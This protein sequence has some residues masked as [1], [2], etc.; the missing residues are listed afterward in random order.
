MANL[1]IVESPSKAAAIKKYLGSNYKVI[2]SKG[3]VR[4]LPKS[5]LSVDIEN[6]FEA[7]YINIRGKGDLIREIRKEA[8]AAKKIFLAPDPD[9]EGEAIAWHLAGALN[10][11]PAKMLRVSFNEITPDVVRAA[12]KEPRAIDMNL[13]NA[14]QTRR[15]WDRVVGYKLS[16]YLWKSVKNGLSAGRVQSV[17][18]RIIVDREE[19]IRAFRPEEYWTIDAHLGNGEGKEFAVR[20]Y[21][22]AEGKIKLSCEQE[23]TDV[24]N[25]VKNAPFLVTSVKRATRQKLPAPPFTTSTMQQEASRKLGFQSQRIMRVAQELYEGINVGPE[26]GGVLGL[27]T[28]MRTDSLRVSAE[29]QNAARE[30]ISEKYGAEYCPAKPRV[31]KTRANAQD[32]HEAIRPSHIDLEPAK[33]HKYLTVDQYRLYKLIWERFVASQ[34]QS[35]S[36]NTLN[37]ELESAGYLFRAG[38]YSVAFPGYM[39]VY[40]ES[41]DEETRADAISEQKDVRIPDLNEGEHVEMR[42]VEPNRHFTE[43]PARY[44]E[45]SLI[46]FLDEKGIGRPSTY[47]TIITTIVTRNYVVRDGKSLVPTPLGEVTTKLMKENFS[48][49]V[50]YTFTAH[51]EDQLDEIEKGNVEMLDVLNDFWRG[52][53]KELDRAETTIGKGS[54]ELPLEETDIICEKCGAKMVVKNGRYGKFAACPNYPNCKNTKPLEEKKEE[55]A[56]KTEKPPVVVADFKCELCG[57]DMVQRTG[58]YGTFFACSRYPACHFTKQKTKELDVP[59][60]KCGSKILIK[61]GRSKTVFYSCEKYPTC[62]FSSWDMPVNEKCPDCGNLLFRKKGKALLVCHEKNCGYRRETEELPAEESAE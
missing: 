42:D 1:V 31:Y 22:N 43:P 15:I 17:A 34:M 12:I 54:F 59:C 19:E 38:G 60:P 32:A 45:A 37:V 13:V 6:G 9:R 47:N 35:A 30:L 58:R 40:E 10:M 16:P 2:A 26:N 4:D 50:D 18:A 57:S 49:I 48:D 61:S 7:H 33:V 24:L 11:D 55:E 62:D 14:Q 20:F 25:A 39:A 36:L 27:I 21:G 44:T 52:F 28:Y 41:E 8:K 56:E 5:S 51:M 29:A 3:H 23:A 46:K 53:S